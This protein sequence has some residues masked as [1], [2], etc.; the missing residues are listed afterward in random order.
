MNAT[1]CIRMKASANSLNADGTKRWVPDPEGQ[2]QYVSLNLGAGR[3]PVWLADVEKAAK[4]G[5]RGFQY[6]IGNNWSEQYPTI[7]EAEQAARPVTAGPSVTK[8]RED[9]TQGTSIRA[10]VEE[11]MNAQRNKRPRSIARYQIT[12]DHL[13]KGLPRSIRTV[14]QLATSKALD[15]Y[16]KTLEG[17][18]SA[19]TIE[20]EM[21]IVFALLKRHKK[22]TGVQEASTLV[23]LPKV[24]SKKAKA[25]SKE[26]AVQLFSKMTEEEYIRYTFFLHTGAREQEV[27]FASWDDVDLKQAKFDVTAKSDVGFIPKNWE[28]RTIPLTTELV[29]L[30]KKRKANRPNKRWIFANEDGNPEGHFLRKFKAIAKEAGLNCGDCETSL[31]ENHLGR[32]HKVEASC[33]TRPIC[34]KH[35]LHRLRKSC[36]TRWLRAGLDLMRIKT[37][38]GHQSLA[39]TQIYLSDEMD[40][41]E[42]ASVDKAFAA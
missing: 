14:K 1:I 31:T 4:N 3:R 20:T 27:A 21:G 37:W 40:G 28:E 22:E 16:L 36:A 25:Y 13:E 12:F 38:L 29:N 39:T 8:D 26:E 33:L 7:A 19:K 6:R 35:Y 2:W 9:E 10:A 23:T 32:R 42:Q 34:E 5:G 17:T 18:Y 41:T 11:F 24:I 30:L 15:A